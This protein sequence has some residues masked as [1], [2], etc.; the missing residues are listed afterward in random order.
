MPL[1]GAALD[2]LNKLESWYRREQARLAM[3][4][5]KVSF[6]T[7]SLAASVADARY[8]GNSDRPLFPYHCNFCGQYHL[9]PR[10]RSG[11]EY[12]TPRQL[13]RTKVFP[14]KNGRRKI[15]RG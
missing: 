4:R 6:A 10:N 12:S 13:R 9:R 3:C 7:F 8:A 14:A 2:L 5:G 1:T 11:A 15:V